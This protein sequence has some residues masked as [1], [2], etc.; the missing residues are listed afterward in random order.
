[1]GSLFTYYFFASKLTL[2][3]DYSSG[4]TFYLQ[5]HLNR[6]NFWNIAKK[7]PNFLLIGSSAGGI[8]CGKSIITSYYKGWDD[9]EIASGHIWNDAN[10]RGSCSLPFLLFMHYDKTSHHDLV[11]Q[12]T[13]E[14]AAEGDT[15]ICLSDNHA[16]ID[17]G[18]DVRI[19]DSN[20]VTV[21][22][23]CKSNIWFPR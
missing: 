9:P 5:Y 12:K 6:V 16:L 19:I 18:V 17:D 1:M 3:L 11:I 21:T 22:H 14:Y 2:F 20:G 8:V 23:D 15:T 13:M 10:L 7:Y 4:N